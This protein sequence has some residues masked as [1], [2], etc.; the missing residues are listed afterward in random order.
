MG[1]GIS[2]GMESG[3]HTAGAVATHFD[4]SETV[5]ETYRLSIETLKSYNAKST[6]VFHAKNFDC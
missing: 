3:Y 4:D 2:A 5:W 6:E 1:E